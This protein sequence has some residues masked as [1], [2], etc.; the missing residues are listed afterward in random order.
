[1]FLRN[2]WPKPPY[3]AKTHKTINPLIG[4]L[5]GQARTQA[6]FRPVH[7]RE[8]MQPNLPEM[9][10]L[11]IFRPEDRDFSRDDDARTDR[12]IRKLVGDDGIEPPTLS[13]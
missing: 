10:A 13:V 2:I 1:M 8:T 5:I 7:C 12:R 11:P 4:P 6:T 3:A 9:I